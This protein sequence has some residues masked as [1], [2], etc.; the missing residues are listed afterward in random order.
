MDEIC[1]RVWNDF[2]LFISGEN[3]G[4]DSKK[5]S[6]DQEDNSLRCNIY[7]VYGNCDDYHSAIYFNTNGGSEVLES[8][9]YS[10]DV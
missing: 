1:S 9:Y 6:K 7:G 4:G 10:P 3:I 5:D 2:V 8:L